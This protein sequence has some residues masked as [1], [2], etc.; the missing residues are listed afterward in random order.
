M[1]QLEA[2]RA[3]RGTS[4]RHCRDFFACGITRLQRGLLHQRGVRG[5][6]LGELAALGASGPRVKQ[7]PQP[8]LTSWLRAIRSCR[9]FS[10]AD[11]PS[12][13]IVGVAA[14]DGLAAPA[15]AL[16]SSSPLDEAASALAST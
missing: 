1:T 9:A 4:K 16:P 15:P 11:T 7:A 5:S 13:P 8:A 6:H 14:G 12:V 2:I 3:H 10:Y